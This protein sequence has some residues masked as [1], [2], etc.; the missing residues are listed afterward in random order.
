MLE[1]LIIFA[2]LFY[3][4]LAVQLAAPAICCFFRV[5]H[6]NSKNASV[7][8]KHNSIS[9]ITYV[10]LIISHFGR[11]MILLKNQVKCISQVPGIHF[12]IYI[13]YIKKCRDFFLLLRFLQSVEKAVILL[14]LLL[15]HNMCFCLFE[16][17]ILICRKEMI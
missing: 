11:Y 13:G 17:V 16:N 9:S 12:H 14:S 7:I 15:M 10:L 5:Y 3:F 2:L 1:I 4:F 6:I 8:H